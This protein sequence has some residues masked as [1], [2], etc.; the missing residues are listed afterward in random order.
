VINFWKNELQDVLVVLKNSENVGLTKSLNKG[1]SAVKTEL[2]AR[3]DTDDQSTPLRF[4]VQEKFM[5]EHPEID[6]LGGAYNIMDDKGVIQ[7]AKYF[8][9]SHEEMLKQICWRCPLSHPTVMMRTS[10]FK[11]KGLKY[12]ERFRNSQDIALWVDA[13]EAGCRFA[14]TD[15]IV[16]NFTEDN[17]VY[18]RRGKVRAM[19]EYKS[20][21]RAAK[22]L[23]GK[24][25]WRR[26]LPVLRYC[27]R[28]MPV[29]S[30]NIIYH[31]KW[32]KNIYKKSE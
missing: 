31:S 23:H 2:I 21:A 26:I 4:E 13:V 17:D 29:K 20:F 22:H 32:F 10:M 16:L 12:D 3:M 19:N 5:R 30:I 1:I 25:S 8:K 11:E 27:F 28:R 9:H 7:Y 24:Y 18:K 15:D 6:V 14:N